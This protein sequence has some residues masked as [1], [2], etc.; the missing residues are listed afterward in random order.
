M[1]P[2]HGQ[3]ISSSFDHMVCVWEQSLSDLNEHGLNSMGL[4]THSSEQWVKC[5]LLT[6]V[7][8]SM[9]SVLMLHVSYYPFQPFMALLLAKPGVPAQGYVPLG[10]MGTGW[11]IV[12]GMH[13]EC[14]YANIM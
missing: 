1:H 12:V 3:F 14:I 6:E 7:E 8:G 2:Q 11:V 10:D 9:R 5:A 4:N 13:N